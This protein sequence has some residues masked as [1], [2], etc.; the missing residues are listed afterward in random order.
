MKAFCT[1][2]LIASACGKPSPAPIKTA[3]S[4]AAEPPTYTNPVI[5]DDFADP[6]VLRDGEWFYAYATQVTSGT[7][8]VNIQGARSRDLIK[9]EP[10][11]DV[12]PTKPT[13]ASTQQDFWAPHV[14]KDNGTYYLYFA[15]GPD[16][17]D[18][19]CIGVATSKSPQGPFQD[20]GKPIKCG[21]GFSVIDA[22]PFVDPKTGKKLM[23][24]GSHHKPIFVQE[25]A[26]NW[27]ELKAGTQPIELIA[28]REIPY[29]RLIEGP[30]ITE[31][32]GYFYLFY[33]GDSCC[34]K[35]ANY[36][37]LVARS[38]SP[39]GP[40]ERKPGSGAPV[41]LAKNERWLAP[42][43]NAVIRDDAG[44]DWMLYHAIDPKQPTQPCPGDATGQML[45]CNGN[46][47]LPSR[48][49]MLIDKIVWRDGWPEMPGAPS[50]TPQ[51]GPVFRPAK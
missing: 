2:I 27:T 50:S 43:H 19:M 40:F 25:M 21:P 46:G 17:K 4:A 30:W 9:W 49:P 14:L 42:G 51:R 39:M 1:V 29:E 23:Y 45:A 15:G 22:F 41:M 11:G 26:D 3:N 6:A 13:W 48:R 32:D 33:S 35:N 20:V 37:V 24:W 8:R 7:R 16:S 44:D 12:L 47:D 38:K 18:G 10:L 28:A 36:A 5:D 31:R 34:G